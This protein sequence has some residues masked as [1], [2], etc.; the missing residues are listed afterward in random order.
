MPTYNRDLTNLWASLSDAWSRFEDKATIEA[1]W[2]G[3]A[4]GSDLILNRTMDVQNSRSLEYMPPILD[5]GPKIISIV[6]SGLETTTVVVE[7]G[8]IFKQYIDDWTL[9]IPTLVQTYTVVSSSGTHTYYE[10]VDYVISGMNTLLWL[11]TPIWD[12]RYP[13]MHVLQL[14]ADSVKRI[15]PIMMNLWARLIDLELDEFNQYNIFTTITNANKYKHLKYFIWAMVYKRLQSPTI[16]N[17]QDALN[18]SLGMPFAYDAGVAT[19]A[20]VG[21]HYEITIGTQVYVLPA[22]LTPCISNGETVAKFDLLA[23]GLY[24]YDYYNNP[25]LVGANSNILTKFNTFLIHKL[26]ALSL[27][28]YSTTFYTTYREKL[29]PVQFLIKDIGPFAMDSTDIFMDSTSIFMDY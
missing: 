26:P 29:L 17:L 22:G 9:S 27:V 12:T 13:S 1:I 6:E 11:T 24:V 2:T 25:S 15:N 18:I 28:T 5:D 3:I 4:A 21:D 7:N 8:G 20:V 10:G 16:K 14:A 19:V 23:R